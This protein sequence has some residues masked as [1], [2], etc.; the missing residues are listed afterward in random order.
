MKFNIPLVSVI[1]PIYN[2]APYLE[3][4]LYSIATQTYINIE[5]ILIN[6]GSTDES[7]KIAETICNKDKRFRLINQTN[8]GVSATRQKGV[9]ISRGDLL[10]H[11]DADDIVPKFAFEKLVN[12]MLSQNSD[13]VVGGYT[14]KYAK[15]DIY[16]GISE[17][18]TYWGFVEGLLSS[19]YH[20]SLCNKL[21]KKEL[22]DLIDFDSDINY[23]EDKLILAKILRDGPYN[24]SFLNEP[25]YIYR[26]NSNS[27]THNL[28]LKSIKSSKIVNQKIINLYNGIVKDEVLNGIKSRQRVFEIYQSAKKGLN[29]FTDED[30]VLIKD[31]GVPSRYRAFLWLLSKNPLFTTK[32]L[33]I[34]RNFIK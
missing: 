17:N 2:A 6:D 16:V 20:G 18:E 11:T 21:I 5:V 29:I 23:M 33:I 22:Y 24:I 34:A 8:L 13:I 3:E 31:T 15:K 1:V 28:S 25:V 14:V 7:Q 30:F 26:K 4:C 32:L 12:R 27:V 9:D 19:K 10:I